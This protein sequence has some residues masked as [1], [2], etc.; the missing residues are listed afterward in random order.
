MLHLV[1]RQP[2]VSEQSST[3]GRWDWNTK[4]ELGARSQ[5]AS[6]EKGGKA[7]VFFLFIIFHWSFF[8]LVFFSFHYIPLLLS[9]I[10]VY[11]F[12]F[13]GG[14]SGKEPACQCMR[15]ETLVWS[16]GWEDPLEEG[17]ATHSSILTWRIP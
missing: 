9:K 11:L 17:T 1:L 12:D 16:L 3:K 10:F 5:G 15:H 8:V 14:T 6:L 13:P 7:M 4:W 2:Q